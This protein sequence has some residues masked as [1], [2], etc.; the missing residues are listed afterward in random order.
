MKKIFISLTIIFISGFN[1]IFAQET[2][3]PVKSP[4]QISLETGYRNV[5][6]V[7]DR[8]N[9]LNGN[10]VR[11]GFGFL[12]DYGW[13]VSG[14]DGSKPAIY[15][16]VPIGYTWMFASNPASKNITM[17]NYGW[18]IRHELSKNRPITPFLGYGLQLN[19]LSMKDLPGGTMGHQTQF[20]FGLNMNTKSHLVYF[21]KI[22]YSYASYP[23]LGDDKRIHYQF[24][25]IRI[26]ARF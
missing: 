10:Q 16:T 12:L 5:F 19:T 22:Q 20:E 2:V 9:V 6:S 4:H 8:S 15:I 11:N 17:L 23:R 21:A 1:N 26:G 14:L 13:K 3:V 18:T 7:I 25:D 24:A